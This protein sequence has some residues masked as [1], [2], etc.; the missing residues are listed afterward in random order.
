MCGICGYIDY[1]NK[2]DNSVLP[3][4]VAAIKHRGPDD[5]GTAFYAIDKYKVALGHAR[6]SILDLSEAGH[7]PMEFDNLTIVFN[8]EIYNFREIRE[9]L[10][11][12]GHTF[13]SESDTEIILHAFKEW[14][15]KCVKQFIGM[16]AFCIYDRNNNRI[17]LFR[18]TGGVKPLYYT[19][20]NEFFAFASE[21]KCFMSMPQFQRE[22]DSDALSAFLKVGYIPGD[23]CIFKSSHK[24]DAGCWLEYNILSRE[25]IINKYW[26]V[27]WFYNKPKLDISY[28]DA[29]EELRQLFKSAFAYRLIS[30]VPVGVLLSGGF[31]SAAVTSILVRELG[32]T[33]LTFTIGFHNHIDE[34]PDAEK[35]A[36]ILGTKHTTQYCTENEIKDIIPQLPYVYDEPFADT[37]ALPTILVSKL[38]KKYVSVVLSAD[39]GDE[40]FAGYY[41]HAKLSK[42]FPMLDLIPKSIRRN[43]NYPIQVLDKI[44]PECMTKSHIF[45]TLLENSFAEK[46]WSYK[47]WYDSQ[48]MYIQKVVNSINRDLSTF[49]YRGIL[50]P[51]V[52]AAHSPEYALVLDYKTQMK[53]EYFVKVD[54]AMMSV[55]LE[56]REPLMDR[57]I[58]EFAAQLPWE[59]KYKNTIKKRI[60]KDLVYDYLPKELMDK[61][62]RGFS[63]PMMKWMRNDLKEYCYN[64]LSSTNLQDTGFNVNATHHVLKSFMK[65]NDHFFGLIWRLVQYHYWYDYWIKNRKI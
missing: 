54:R 23:M 27:E 46:D 64:S 41:R 18:D 36:S 56:G 16:F 1:K 26:D 20:D 14:G 37:S 60:L 49:D 63:P 57:R 25:F 7:Q 32:I 43:S 22:I 21:L 2:I 28:E 17:Y 6:L 59:F 13:H 58:I 35:I 4:M 51:F 39:G 38:V 62:K 30:D 55:S 9:V 3:N 10:K 24:L 12:K 42:I 48:F 47:A 31:D 50:R 5:N 44:L 45:L 40:I 33:P 29:K 11:D 52:A 19:I 8:G 65:G 61:P 53:D 34:A 15:A